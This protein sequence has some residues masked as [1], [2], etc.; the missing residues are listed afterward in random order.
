MEIGL[1][2]KFLGQSSF[3]LE[4]SNTSLLID[5]GSKKSGDFPGNAVY[6][7]HGHTDHIAGVKTFLERNSESLLYCNESV[8]KKFKLYKDRIR[9]VAPGKVLNHGSWELRFA[10]FR[11]GI[12]RWEKNTGIIITTGDTVF[13]HVGDA[14]EYSGFYRED[15]NILAIPI[16]GIVTTSP[17][18]ALK[19]LQE[20]IKVP[21]YI[22][23]MHWIWRNLENFCKDFNARFPGSKCLIPE[24][25][26]YIS[27]T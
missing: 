20:F 27:I 4:D 11:H 22:I 19:D 8:A 6:V 18:K 13:G 2:I 23:P 26:T 7:T 5:P 14:K 16:S 15:L 10:N 17:K 9:E 21:E 24:K 25:G 1:K 12:F 3:L